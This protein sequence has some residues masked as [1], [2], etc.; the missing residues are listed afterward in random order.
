MKLK[1]KI[2]F[3]KVK[4]SNSINFS[5]TQSQPLMTNPKIKKKNQ[6]EKLLQTNLKFSSIQSNEKKK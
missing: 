3:K 1:N 4:D 2:K 6:I 5:H